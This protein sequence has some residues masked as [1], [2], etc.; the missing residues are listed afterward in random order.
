MLFWSNVAAMN[1]DICL[2]NKMN[3]FMVN[4]ETLNSLHKAVLL[5]PKKVIY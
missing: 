4:L 1:L 2:A 3:W 5:A